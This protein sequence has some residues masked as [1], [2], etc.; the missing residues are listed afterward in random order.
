ML[1]LYSYY[2]SSAA[3]RVRLALALKGL[4][5]DI[6]PVHL[7]RDG[8]EHKKADYLAIN[9]QARVPSLKLDDGTILLQ[10]PAILEYLEEAYPQ[11][12][13]LPR[14]LVAR[15][16]VRAIVA[17][18]CCDIH[19]INNSGTL[20]K[21]RQDFAADDQA[22]TA[23]IAHWVHTSFVAIEGLIEAAPYCFGTEPTLA[24]LSLIPQVFAAK[25][26][27]VPLDAFPKILSVEKAFL[28]LPGVAAA[29]P[30]SQPDTE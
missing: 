30:L 19:P 17:M 14:G 18:I 1:T 27:A 22:I 23:W 16:R 25:R 26:F 29:H 2:R 10:S 28:A 9:P 8:G 20:A 21:L 24:D 15:A 5:H 13:L 12:A 4:S 6:V 11:P 3:Y 7:V